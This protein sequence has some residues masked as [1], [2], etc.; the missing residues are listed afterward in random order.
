MVGRTAPS[1]LGQRIRVV[2]GG[3]TG[4]EPMATLVGVLLDPHPSA[5]PHSLIMQ[6]AGAAAGKSTN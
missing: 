2:A 4:S 5:T 6:A 1:H 3:L